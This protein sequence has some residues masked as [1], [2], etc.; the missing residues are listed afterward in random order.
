MGAILMSDI[1]ERSRQHNFFQHESQEQYR[2][3]VIPSTANISNTLREQ[4]NIFQ[5][6]NQGEQQ[7]QEFK[8]QLLSGHGG[9]A[10]SIQEFNLLYDLR[11]RK[12]ADDDDIYKIASSRELGEYLEI[13]PLY[14]YDNYDAIWQA[15]SNDRQDRYASPKSRWQAIRDSVQI[16]KNNIPQGNMGNELKRL[17]TMLLTANGAERDELQRQR[18]NLWNEILAIRN[19]NEELARRFPTD[20]LTTI[21]TSTIQSAPLTGKSMLGGAIGAAAA[22][23]IGAIT[24]GPAGAV[25][26]LRIGY[27][28]GSFAAS[29]AEMTGLL[30]VDLLAAG[31]KQQNAAALAITGGALNGV[32]ESGLGVVAG[33][34]TSAV[35]AI[36]GR[37]L[38]QEVQKQIAEAASKNFIKRITQNVMTSPV[39][40]N[41]LTRTL[42]STA[43][44]TAGE[45]LEEGLQ[46]LVEH[47]MFALGDAMQDA[48]VERDSW[49][50]PEFWEEFKNSIIGG[51]AGGVGFGIIGLP[52]NIT[53][54][55][56]QTARQTAEL[57][58]LAVTIDDKAE[59]RAAARQ[60]TLAA[61]LSDEKIDQM[62]DSHEGERVQYNQAM[63]EEAARAGRHVASMPT[64]EAPGEMRRQANGRLS[65]QITSPEGEGIGTIKIFDPP[66]R[67][68]MGTLEFSWDIESN[69]IAI[70][71]ISISQAI[72]NRETVIG[73]M[74]KELAY[75]NPEMGINW[76]PDEKAS[77]AAGVDLAA[78]KDKLTAENPHGADWGLQFYQKGDRFVQTSAM[79]KDIDLIASAANISRDIASDTYEAW[80]TA[81]R[82]FGLDTHE[83]ISRMGLTNES[84]LRIVAADN[85]EGV[86]AHVIKQL[87]Q[88]RIAAQKYNETPAGGM[89][90]IKQAEE[91]SPARILKENEAF[92]ETLDQLR[93]ITVLTEKANPSTLHH[94]WLHFMVN[95]VIPNS[96]RYRALLEDAVGK[97]LEDFTK[98]DHE[99][100]AENYERYLRTGEAPTPG[101]KALFKRIAQALKDFVLHGYVSPKLREFFDQMLA[102][103]DA[104]MIKGESQQTNETKSRAR[105]KTDNEQQR[106]FAE[107]T[108]AERT[109]QSDLHSAEEKAE[110]LFAMNR[111]AAEDQLKVIYDQYH[112]QDGTAKAGWLKA[113]NG[114]DTNLTEKQWLA[115]RTPS[116][117]KWFGDWEALLK[118]EE[119]DALVD[120]ALDLNKEPKSKIYLRGATPEEIAE[121]KKQGGPDITGLEHEITSEHIRHIIKEHGEKN[122]SIKHPDQR[123]I[124][125]DD[126]SLLPAV[127]DAPTEITVKNIDKN[128]TSVIYGKDFGKGK[129][130][131]VERIIETSVKN[132]PRLT[133]K[134]AWVKATTGA[135]PST[136]AVYTPHRNSNIL[137]SNGRVN[138]D[139]VSKVVDENGEPLV[140]FHGT[141]DIFDTYNK[142]KLSSREGSFFFTSNKIASSDYGPIQM[143]V[144]LNIKNPADYNSYTITGSSK[145]DD[146][147][148]MKKDGY[149]GFY[150]DKDTDYNEWSAFEPNQIKSATDNIGSFD[151]QTDNIYFQIIGEQGTAA[152]DKAE[153]S[154]HRLDNLAIARQ[155]EEAKKDAMVIRAATGWERGADSKWRYEIPDIEINEDGLKRINKT[156]LVSLKDLVFAEDL[157]KAYPDINEKNISH[158]GNAKRLKNYTVRKEDSNKFD[159]GFSKS[160]KTISIAAYYFE[161]NIELLKDVLIHEIQHA[162]QEIEGFAE[163]GDPNV[164]SE[165]KYLRVAGEVEARNAQSRLSMSAERRAY[166]MLEATEDVSRE[167]QIFI[168][169]NNILFQLAYH[170]S[171]YKFIRFDSSH[172]GSGEGAQAYGWGHYFASNKEVAQW[173]K[174]RLSKKHVT[175][176]YNGEEYSASGE[177]F[178]PQD[179]INKNTGEEIER[180]NDL[181]LLFR[182]L[183]DN[184]FKKEEA[185][186]KIEYRLKQQYITKEEAQELKIKLNDIKIDEGQ[187]YEVDIPGDEE[188]LDWDKKLE[189][190][191][192][193]ILTALEKIVDNGLLG[194]YSEHYQTGEALYRMLSHEH[195]K[196]KASMILSEYGIKGIRYLD[197]SSRSAGEGSYNYVI[198]DDNEINITNVF[199]Q[200]TREDIHA[201]ALRHSSWKAWMEADVIA[202]TFD[203]EASYRRDNAAEEPQSQTEKEAWYE[204]QWNEAQVLA[205]EAALGDDGIRI[206]ANAESIDTA[207]LDDEESNLDWL[208][209][210][211]EEEINENV[212]ENTDNVSGNEEYVNKP[213][214]TSE[215]NRR[216]I[217]KLPRIIDDFILIIGRTMRENL[218]HF[219]ALTEEDAAVRDQIERDKKRIYN[220]VHPYIR[221][222]ALRLT[223]GKKLS[224]TQRR[225]VMTHMMRSLESGAT[226]YREIYTSLTEDQEFASYSKNE[227]QDEGAKGEAQKA[228]KEVDG[229]TAFQRTK[230]AESI[231][232]KD[233]RRKIH[234]SKATSEEIEEYIDRRNEEIKELNNEIKNAKTELKKSQGETAEER[235]EADSWRKQYY[236]TRKE[237]QAS[238]KELEQLEKKLIQARVTRTNAL[239]RAKTG[240]DKSEA[241]LKEQ[242][243][244][245]REKIKMLNQ[246]LKDDVEYAKKHERLKMAWK[247]AE[248]R[249]TLKKKKNQREQMI[250]DRKA[251]KKYIEACKE[252]ASWN[253]SADRTGMD[254]WVRQRELILGIQN[255]LFYASKSSKVTEAIQLD[256][257]IKELNK[258]INKL[259]RRQ[260]LLKDKSSRQ[261]EQ[262]KDKTKWQAREKDESLLEEIKQKLKP[263]EESLKN[264][265]TRRDKIGISPLEL[266]KMRFDQAWSG[267]PDTI[268]TGTILYNGKQMSV[269]Q[270][271]KDFY[272][273]KIRY[274][275]MDSRLRKALRKSAPSKESL[276]EKR[277]YSAAKLA[278]SLSLEDLLAIKAVI[279]QLNMEGKA[280]WNRRKF[281]I[282]FEQQEKIKLLLFQQDEL[283]EEEK[284]TGDAKRY[285]E[286]MK[287]PNIKERE[288]ILTEGEKLRETGFESLDNKRLAQH[289]DG[290]RKRA[291]YQMLIRDQYRYAN[292]RDVAVEQRTGRILDILGQGTAEQ[293]EAEKNLSE[294]KQRRKRH[295]RAM[296]VMKELKRTKIT[297]EGIGGCEEIRK[298]EYG[299]DFKLEASSVLQHYEVK[300]NEGNII[301]DLT[302]SNVE[303]SLADLMFLSVALKNKFSREH[304]IFGNFWSKDE[305]AYYEKLGGISKEQKKQIETTKCGQINKAIEKYIQPRKDL[306]QII[307]AIRDDF[308]AH[309][310]ET[311]ATFEDMFNQVVEPQ[312][313]YLP[314]IIN[315]EKHD[316]AEKQSEIEALTIGSHQVKINP[317]KGMNLARVDIGPTHQ[318]AIETDIFNVYFKGVEREEHFNKF[319][320]YVRDLNTVLRGMN[321]NSKQLASYL[322][323]MHGKW[324]VDRIYKHINM[325]GLPPSA[326]LHNAMDNASNLGRLL[327]GNAGVAFI[328]YNIPAWLAQYPNSIAAFFGKADARFILS[329]LF[330]VMKPGSDLVE[331]VFEKSPKVKNRVINVAEEFRQHLEKQD[332]KLKEIHAKFIEIGMMGQRHADQT[333]VAA[334]WYALYQTA[335]KD[336]KSEED[337]VVFA[338]EIT[339]ET[340]PDLNALETSPMFKEEGAGK[341]FLRFLEP[342]NKVWQNLTY[343]S[344]ISREKSFAIVIPRIIAYGTAALIVAAMRGALSNKDDEEIE[345]DE[346]IRKVFYYMLFAQITESV[347]YI[348]SMVSGTAERLITGEGVNYQQRYFELAQRVLNIPEKLLKENFEG[349]IKDALSALSL[350]AGLPISQINRIIKSVQEEDP[351]II[352]GYN[353]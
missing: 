50:S 181:Y 306:L 98:R 161:N 170:G 68:Q 163:G 48:P 324:A 73:D 75:K 336:G 180:N 292:R 30:Y 168:Q 134:T 62:Y 204:K 178:F 240:R 297:V 6:W 92:K 261:Q 326:K 155:M 149:D 56:Q 21:A 51:L 309:H 194:Y 40:R 165:E 290:D 253:M 242:I 280:N 245:L 299:M 11:E 14:V 23:A 74:I 225:T 101:L 296:K 122:E 107:M 255:A 285:K 114:K 244:A 230:I 198:F 137:F 36:G 126:I 243:S 220:E 232:D 228:A 112:N 265:Q 58:N 348:G 147:T 118:Q 159:G 342:L 340:Q 179:L 300:D 140:V 311:R 119:F 295:N 353:P 19:A 321:N 91:G 304:I 211:Y 330:E 171:P 44:Q 305:Q 78:L 237:L 106:A 116:F 70:E 15:I 166:I 93:A 7:R 22:G 214:T 54:N 182:Y 314:I 266:S 322:K 289:M 82:N 83:M 34:G 124:T 310:P 332:G 81:F 100:L 10:L 59:Y 284:K 238:N 257:D 217:A 53:G 5:Q 274:G 312:E 113:P 69:S 351:W 136:S 234:A 272:E 258:K 157:F 35:R 301:P 260:E 104:A 293:Q 252:V 233:I 203:A 156:G 158:P 298:W 279:Q 123:S 347:P 154:T 192:K 88:G 221:G 143:G 16:A 76:N 145:R 38:S 267:G 328:A 57:K 236:K 130:C 20:A 331:K 105:V 167:D 115:V 239:S 333:M 169:N 87:D 224:D 213:I 95:V 2:Q 86:E 8:N 338:D 262:T 209:D 12:L 346:M 144:F 308:E 24:G 212:T 175:F 71:N 84:E 120:E 283:L 49:G 176:T 146:V 77:A 96:P 206:P 282:H 249:R 313:Y 200:M 41:A 334:G 345:K 150:T 188:I 215:A 60:V 271:R 263:L 191:P 18:D 4:K 208:P 148:Q 227:I 131:Y 193:N 337:A 173:Y 177:R 317:D 151:P 72:T 9:S 226:V 343:D 254:I 349:A 256:A 323:K 231:I 13:D 139:S 55:I 344:F 52:L 302:G 186:R 219:N 117:K 3:P 319:A 229:L 329:S 97:K 276:T 125:K 26:G 111:L 162:I 235:A 199:F 320:P 325:V 37:V 17:D 316:N 187:L 43:A 89:V 127:I 1:F 281:A 190:Q 277:K 90:V 223:T 108:G 29:S 286:A 160:S 64:L 132:K 110:I 202:E 250:A 207:L 85:P 247:W 109:L 241:K 307:D 273:K 350:G 205:R 251:A 275:F 103:S 121:V 201:E 327:A 79:N 269:E 196:Q 264:L 335:L 135:K 291:F 45:G 218:A 294:Y 138:P 210:V 65:L 303:L 39:G 318:T 339:S 172:M 94:E 164:L 248:E 141:G 80:D 287:N 33:W 142:N 259:K 152:L 195:G 99:W 133:L 32:I 183:S 189:K 222:V 63:R 66:T 128:L 47:A 67:Q 28:L 270:F 185:A 216:L 315:E 153:E 27:G 352:F 197:G 246:K 174:D 184:E 25:G 61:N 268:D 42:F 129:I 46:F 31:V 278:K 102:G 288:K 341:L